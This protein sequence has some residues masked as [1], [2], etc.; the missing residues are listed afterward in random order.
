M[1]QQ[2]DVVAFRLPVE[3][4]K[5]LRYHLSDLLYP[6]KGS[7]LFEDD[8]YSHE[9]NRDMSKAT[10][11]VSDMISQLNPNYP[12]NVMPHEDDDR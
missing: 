4:I 1:E 3:D 2:T 6:H 7:R 10:R 11:V 5:N 9:G 12:A 8:Y